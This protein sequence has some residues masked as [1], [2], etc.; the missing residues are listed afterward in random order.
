MMAYRLLSVFLFL[1]F[2]VQA[3][4]NSPLRE[5]AKGSFSETYSEIKDEIVDAILSQRDEETLSDEELEDLEETLSRYHESPIDL[6][7]SRLRDQL[8]DLRFLNFSQIESLCRYVYEYGP[9]QT[10]HELSLVKDLRQQDLRN[11]LPFIEIGSSRG[12]RQRFGW[13]RALREGKYEVVSKYRRTVETRL[14]YT[15]T[16]YKKGGR[17]YLGSPDY[18]GARVR[19]HYAD[20]IYVGL[21]MEKDPGEQFWNDSIKG[22]D[23]YNFYVQLDRPL[24]HVS[25][26]CLGDFNVQWG[27]GLVVNTFF[28]TGIQD[29]LYS[30]LSS[31]SRIRRFSGWSERPRF[32]GVATELSF[33]NHVS[34]FL[35]GSHYEGS[36]SVSKQGTFTHL[37]TDGYHRTL[38]EL[39]HKDSVIANSLGSRL[40]L[41]WRNAEW[42]MNVLNTH[43]S[44][45]CVPTNQEYASRQFYGQD[46]FGASTDYRAQ[47]RRMSFSGEVATDKNGHLAQ[48]HS[49][50]CA[51][52]S[53]LSLVASYR[54]YSTYYDQPF[55]KAPEE[56]GRVNG[57]RGVSVGYM[58]APSSRFRLTQHVDYYSFPFLKY[59]ISAPTE[60]CDLY[61]RCDYN[62]DKKT[63]VYLRL[64]YRARD[65]DIGSKSDKNLRTLPYRRHALTFS[66]T[67]KILDDIVSLSERLDVNRAHHVDTLSATYGYQLT[68]SLCFAP[69]RF[70]L[71]LHLRFAYFNTDSYDNVI[72]T[73]ENDVLYSYSSFQANGEGVRWYASLSY[74]PI[75]DLTLYAKV[76][77]TRRW[78]QDFVGSNYDRIDKNHK[79]DVSLL[80]RLYF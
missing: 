29:M 66:V 40:Q 13:R 53:Y 59:R 31:Y 21:A 34:L 23:S 77:Q 48:I 38:S 7:G 76:G 49:L 52:T 9:I 32:R 56:G 54:D 57:E 12:E 6:N 24:R 47:W 51:A 69:H 11:L 43:F 4:A 36:A 62:P 50:G 26:L 42:G 3:D 74:Q 79:T 35:L 65:A 10:L 58:Y 27:R 60:G 61:A 63:D 73:Y 2:T 75:K 25:T 18:V 5:Y 44:K 15:D 64:R 78:D 19:Y 37:L 67:R 45:M 71:R 1:L 17:A 14:G 20:R 30:G 68:S 46:A 55:A 80:V 8:E 72:Y 39:H 28:N 70:P 41:R 33:G 16:A 22:F